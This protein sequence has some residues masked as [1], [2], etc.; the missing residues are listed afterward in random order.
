[1]KRQLSPLD[2]SKVYRAVY[3]RDETCVACQAFPRER[4][5]CHHRSAGIL[6]CH[7]VVPQSRLKRE[8]S[9]E[10]LRAALMDPRGCVLLGRYHHGQ[11]EA[12]MVELPVP[13]HVVQFC[14]AY[15][16]AWWLTRRAA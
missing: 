9:G 11:A 4:W 3:D 6:D 5:K 14:R 8:L 1:M 13:E 15:D 10:R 2:C 12:C 7:H 16:L